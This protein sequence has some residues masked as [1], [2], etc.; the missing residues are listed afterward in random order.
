MTEGHIN[1]GPGDYDAHILQTIPYYDRIHQEIMDLVRSWDATPGTWLDT[2]CGTG[3]LVGKALSRFP[4]TRFLLADPSEA[5]LG[6]ARVKLEGQD[7]VRF[8]GPACS[9]ELVPLVDERPDLITAVQCH[10]YLSKGERK[11]A[12]AACF[13]LLPEGGMYV[14]FENVRPF[15]ARGVEIVGRRWECFQME[16]G[17]TQEDA[18]AHL[19]RFDKEYFPI[20]VEEHLDLYRGIGFRTVEM[21]WYSCMQAG[22]YCLK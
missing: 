22:F 11:R 20:T 3:A 18:R 1:Y 9:Q 2:G 7:R 6:A 19:D 10:H 15:T 16:H 5:M 8:L 17:K 12:V 14:T 21:L 4:S 13:D